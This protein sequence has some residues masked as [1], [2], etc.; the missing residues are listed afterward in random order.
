MTGLL[1]LAGLVLGIA[2]A[3]KYLFGGTPRSTPRLDALAEKVK[4]GKLEWNGRRWV[5]V[6]PKPKPLG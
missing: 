6:K 3:C 2:C 4:D 1:L 5:E